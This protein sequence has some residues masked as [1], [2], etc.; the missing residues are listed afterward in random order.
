V[1]QGVSRFHYDA[2]RDRFPAETHAN[3][4]VMSTGGLGSLGN[5]L[6]GSV[7]AQVIK[8]SRSAHADKIALLLQSRR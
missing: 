4:I 3:Q 5:L 7:A 6:L 8:L 2:H 1:P